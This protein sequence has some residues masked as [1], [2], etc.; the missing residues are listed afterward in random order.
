[1][2]FG[3]CSHLREMRGGGSQT[4]HFGSSRRKKPFKNLGRLRKQ[5]ED[6]EGC[7][8]EKAYDVIKDLPFRQGDL[9]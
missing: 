4:N 8:G 5:I 1:M 6:D 7:E 9:S 2:E 3:Q